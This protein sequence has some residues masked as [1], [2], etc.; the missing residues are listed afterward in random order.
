M[1]PVQGNILG[2]REILK[3]QCASL[4]SFTVSRGEK[5]MKILMK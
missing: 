5:N 4:M 2:A 1:A 3:I